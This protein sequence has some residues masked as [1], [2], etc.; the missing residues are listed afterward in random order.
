MTGNLIYDS[1][2]EDHDTGP[3]HP[4]GP[5]RVTVIREGCQKT[6]NPPWT[7]L[8]P[9]RSATREELRGVH[10]P[11]YIDSV[12][13]A[14]ET[15]T[16]LDADTPVSSKSYTTA[17]RAAGS[18]LMLAERAHREGTPG[19]GAVRPPGH[20]AEPARGMGFCLFNNVAVA[21][22]SMTRL[23][24]TVG[25]VDIDVHHG[26]GT[27]EM[28]YR[29][30]DVFYASF[31]QFPFYPGSGRETETGE[32]P[33]E[34]TTCNVPLAAGAD[35]ADLEP[36]FHGTILR[37]LEVFSPDCLMVSAG[38]DA[39]ESDPIG[40]LNLTDE[41]FLRLAD[42]LHQFGADHCGGQITAVL[43]GGYNRK[44]LRRLVPRFIARLF[45]EDGP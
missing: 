20:H 12:R 14:A 39:H 33:G 30:E 18:F 5:D 21:A 26:N 8:D 27:Q 34:G 2:F 9:T 36:R 23:E 29:R 40:G 42:L 32:G 17:L 38:F 31:H 37:N 1:L 43:E 11:E 16:A 44:T 3:H 41:D 4:E 22:H 25:I 7:V 15:E 28:F 19:F 13:D 24:Q 35:W 6:Q 10:E 45:G